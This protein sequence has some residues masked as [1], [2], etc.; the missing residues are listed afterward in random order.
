VLLLLRF[1]NLNVK[2]KTFKSN[3]NN[4]SHISLFNANFISSILEAEHPGH[5]KIY[6]VSDRKWNY[7]R[8]NCSVSEFFI[9]KG[10]PP[11]LNILRSFVE[12]IY[13]WLDASPLNIIVVHCRGRK[14]DRTVVMIS[15]WLVASGYCTSVSEAMQLV[16]KMLSPL[17]RP[18][19]IRY[20]KYYGKSLKT[21]VPS[22]DRFI[23]L[24]KIRLNTIPNFKF[25]G[26][27][28]PWF[29]IFQ[30]GKKVF[31]TKK[32]KGAK[33]KKVVDFSCRDISLAGDIKIEFY[34]K[35]Y[36]KQMFWFAFNTS[37]EE[38]TGNKMVLYKRDLDVACADTDNHKF[39]GNFKVEL[40]FIT[41]EKMQEVRKKQREQWIYG[42]P[43]SSDE[44]NIV[45]TVS[46]LLSDEERDNRKK[47]EEGRAICS[48]CKAHI[49][50]EECAISLSPTEIVHWACLK[51]G[52]C[53]QSLQQTSQNK[54]CV[55][56]GGKMI[57]ETCVEGFFPKCQQCKESITGKKMV[58]F[59]D[60]RWHLQCA[61]CTVCKTA[62]TNA[63][64]PPFH[65]KRGA[66]YCAT[67]AVHS[68][69]HVQISLLLELLCP[70]VT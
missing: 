64:Q 21:G 66:L 38:L 63:T 65:V 27:C 1:L 13:K 67:C 50:D 16:G 7:S 69:Y 9:E 45:K 52:R 6:N 47:A 60:L 61:Q 46:E 48:V 40:F 25:T 15:A 35:D 33:G 24:H 5:Y 68:P 57:C 30:Q 2:S 26:G 11:T 59:G 8:V 14:K 43:N 28:D 39:Y 44:I 49:F 18:S 34:H 23:F 51:C 19:Q 54:Q 41:T 56:Q 4:S 3:I 29:S 20:L 42:L 55:I 70:I 12:D 58:T 37:F 31:Y 32:L 62:L 22:K 53:G 10:Q 36:H 17:E